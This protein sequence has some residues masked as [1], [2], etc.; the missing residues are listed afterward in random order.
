[1][2]LPQD[3]FKEG[4]VVK[5]GTHTM[6][7]FMVYHENFTD[8]TGDCVYTKSWTL[9]YIYQTGHKMGPFTRNQ[10]GYILSIRDSFVYE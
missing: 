6:V 1:M 8:Q 3:I 4:V 2:V 7:Y 9:I 5:H 10:F